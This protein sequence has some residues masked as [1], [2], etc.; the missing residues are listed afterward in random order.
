MCA[1]S[2]LLKIN[3]HILPLAIALKC[4]YCT[5]NVK[6]FCGDPM[7]KYTKDDKTYHYIDCGTENQACGKLVDN[8]GGE[9]ILS[10]NFI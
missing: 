2:F 5:S 1:N 8:I 3:L 10:T 4:W 6:S 9:H 7:G